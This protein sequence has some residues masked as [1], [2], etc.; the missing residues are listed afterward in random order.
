MDHHALRLVV[1][2]FGSPIVSHVCNV[3]ESQIETLLVTGSSDFSAAQKSVMERLIGQLNDVRIRATVEGVPPWLFM[4]TY[5]ASG[6]SLGS[7]LN[8]WRRETG[9]DLPSPRSDDP[10]LSPLGEIAVDAYPLLLLASH[11]GQEQQAFHLARASGLSLANP[12]G[13]RFEAAVLADERLQRLFPVEADGSRAREGTYFASTGRGGPVQLFVLANML[14]TSA[15]LLTWLRGERSLGGVL[16]AIVEVV[17]LVRTAA[18]GG[19]VKVP[20]FV[21]FLNV[22]LEPSTSLLTP[23]GQIRAW[24]PMWE[25]LIPP[26]LR[27][28]TASEDGRIMGFVLETKFPYAISAGGEEKDFPNPPA[29]WQRD[30]QRADSELTRSIEQTSLVF[31]LAIDRR[32]PVAATRSWTLIIDPLT[33]GPALN[34][35]FN[36]TQVM[37]PYRIG[38]DDASA[39]AEWATTL[40]SVDDSKISIARRRVLSALSDRIDPVDSFVDAVIVWENL[41]GSGGELGFRISTA[42]AALLSSEPGERLAL[43]RAISNLYGQR[44]SVVHGHTSLSS[45]EALQRRDDALGYALRALRCL[46]RDHPGWIGAGDIAQR[47]LLTGDLSEEGEGSSTT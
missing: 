35:T 17:E 45:R 5:G 13:Q 19:R 12:T 42:M 8:G 29:S 41:F 25:G 38:G 11:P 36:R 28:S 39:L 27:P 6:A 31:P 14:V 23:W 2:E 46:Y 21:G 40:H 10:V 47:I 37:D 15:Y 3:T 7:I 4:G 1:T 22:S 9:G 32:P 24:E 33:F 20:A 34:W 30:S 26:E 16:E 44:S 43:Q 18:T